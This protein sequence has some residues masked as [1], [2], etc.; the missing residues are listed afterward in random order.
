MALF[1]NYMQQMDDAEVPEEGRILYVTPDVY[2][3]LK[4]AEQISRSLIV[5][6]NPGAVNRAVRSLDDVAI[7]K[8]PSARMKTAY[9]FSDGF[10][11]G[12]APQE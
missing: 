4:Q 7:T 11:M 12:A 1:D 8:V 10:K 5:T 3:S 9:D 2:K 6:N